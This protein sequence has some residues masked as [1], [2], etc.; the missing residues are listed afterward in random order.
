MP[1]PAPLT[2]VPTLLPKTWGGRRLADFGKRLPPGEPIGESWELADID[3]TSPGGAGGGAVRSTIANGPLAGRTLRDAMATWGADLTGTLD[4]G[5]GGAFPLLVKLL[6]AAEDL[7]VQVH[8]SEA[9][10]A[11]HPGTAVKHETW[12]VLHADPGAVLYKGI[13]DGIDLASLA[14]RVRAGRVTAALEPVPARVGDCHHLPSGTVHALGRGIAVVEIQTPS[15]TTYRLW[16]WPD[17]YRRAGRPLHV[18]AALASARDDRPPPA[19]TFGES[20]EGATRL[21]DAGAYDVWEVRALA[22]APVARPP[23]SEACTVLV[24]VG[25]EL[26]WPDGTGETGSAV[27]GATVLVPPAFR[28]RIRANEPSRVLAIGFPRS[29]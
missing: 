22:G 15:D 11:G 12:Y 14:D 27:A 18:D 20:A 16:D 25:G 19:T 10:A 5:P 13:R 3:A 1:G 4:L 8:P 7:S 6:D 9:Y 17:R 23:A 21:A 28:D 2:F 26:S 29:G 24:V